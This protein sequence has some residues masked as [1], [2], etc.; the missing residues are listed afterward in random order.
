[1]PYTLVSFHAH[2]D[3]AE[4]T[5]G[6]TMARA[7]AE[8]HRVVL[9]LATSGELGEQRP[10]TVADGESLGERRVAETMAAAEILGVD[11]VVFL[12]YRDSG[13]AGE[14]TN[15]AEGAF[16]SADV[17]EAAQ[18]LA[19]VLH[20]EHADVLTTYD[21]HGGYGHPDHIQVHRVG[22]R[23]AD[24]AGNVVV[25]EYSINRDHL[26]RLMTEQPDRLAEIDEA[27]RPDPEFIA[28]LG[29]P[30]SLLTTTVDVRDFVFTKRAALA[31]HTSQ[32]GPEHFFLAMPDD[33]FAASFG[34]EWYIRP[35][36]PPGTH[37]TSL[38]E[39]LPR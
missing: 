13:M 3:D 8:G 10:G 2:P 14:P 31:A 28:T 6:G 12:G 25:Y 34:W 36:A 18:R 9:V 35:G 22:A 19:R 21:D 5:T 15:D 7:K 24:L 32:V 16:W 20:E 33:V 38:F 23:A 27:E 11:R 29:S 37:E 30:E 26:R 39:R 1:V 17:D 4:I